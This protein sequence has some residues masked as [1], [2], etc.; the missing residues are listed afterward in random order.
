MQ[1]IDTVVIV[2]IN[3]KTSVLSFF[4][5]FLFYHKY[6]FPLCTKAFQNR[7]IFLYHG[8]NRFYGLGGQPY[9]YVLN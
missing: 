1:V 3:K 5:D 7:W 2:L 4:F 8:R 6:S 9:R